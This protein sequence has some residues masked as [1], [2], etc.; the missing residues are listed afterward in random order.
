MRK[1]HFII[2]STA[3]SLFLSSFADNLRVLKSS[4]LQ[5]MYLMLFLNLRHRNQ[6][7]VSSLAVYTT[8]HILSFYHLSLGR[9]FF[10]RL[11]FLGSRWKKKVESKKK[12]STKDDEALEERRKA[13]KS[14]TSPIHQHHVRRTWGNPIERFSFLLCI[15]SS[16]ILLHRPF[17]PRSLT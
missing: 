2:K 11:F 4:L 9:F 13:W 10:C 5:W 14:F 1:K 17:S 3:L 7:T 16:C 8:A 12:S 6:V 15:P